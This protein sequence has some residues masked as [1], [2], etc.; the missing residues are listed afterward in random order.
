M[1]WTEVGIEVSSDLAD[2][3]RDCLHCHDVEVVAVEITDPSGGELTLCA[4]RA[5][6]PASSGV[7]AEQHIRDAL[8]EQF[9]FRLAMARTWRSE[10][11][12]IERAPPGT[13]PLRIGRAVTQPPWRCWPTGEDDIAL[14][15]LAGPGFGCG[16]HGTTRLVV[17]ELQQLVQPGMRVL[18]VGTGCGLAAMVAARL[19]ATVVALDV[20]EEAV[21]TARRNVAYNGLADR[22]EVVI[23][24]IDC[25]HDTQY[26]L[27]VHN[28]GS[29]VLVDMGTALAGMLGSGGWLLGSGVLVDF[30]NA[31]IEGLARRGLSAMETRRQ[32]RWSMVV[33][34]R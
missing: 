13:S 29:P 6:L 24:S 10:V 2:Q 25:I 20:D 5:Y 28:I 31:V 11:S 21:A 27:A 9:G 15:L 33:C 22:I 18:D 1:S 30:E 34:R 4:V 17:E 19:G 8:W 32:G 7:E 16:A 12:S 3:V 26:D 14:T 23:G